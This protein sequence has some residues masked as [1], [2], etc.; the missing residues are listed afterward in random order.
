VPPAPGG[1]APGDGVAGEPRGSRGRTAEAQLCFDRAVA[2]VSSGQVSGA[3]ALLRRALALSPR[4][5]E[6]S[7]LLAQLAFRDRMPPH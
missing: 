7:A 1:L 4:D 6:I 2:A 5:P 3:I